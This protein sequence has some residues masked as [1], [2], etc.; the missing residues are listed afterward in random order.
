MLPKYC[1]SRLA[2]RHIFT[3]P[4][5]PFFGVCYNVIKLPPI[6][7]INFLVMFI[8][9]KAKTKIYLIPSVKI[10]FFTDHFN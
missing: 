4:A 7:I 8:G 5:Y 10:L 1:V 3:L 9:K 6:Q 2:D